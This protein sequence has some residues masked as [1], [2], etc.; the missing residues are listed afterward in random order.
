[1]HFLNLLMGFRDSDNFADVVG[2]MAHAQEQALSSLGVPELRLK[3]RAQTCPY[4]FRS[5][6]FIVLT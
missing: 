4:H 1:M 6:Q 2:L 5:G 3:A